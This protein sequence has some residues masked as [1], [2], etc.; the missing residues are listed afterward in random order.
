MSRYAAEIAAADAE[1]THLHR[2]AKLDTKLTAAEDRYS[3]ISAMLREATE[4]GLSLSVRQG[5][6]DHTD[7]ARERMNEITRHMEIS[8]R[9]HAAR[10]A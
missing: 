5:L 1:L 8:E 9:A 10:K 7:L 4:L 6:Q 3:R 2:M